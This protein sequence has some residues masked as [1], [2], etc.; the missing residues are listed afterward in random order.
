MTQSA[1]LLSAYRA[2]SHA[3]WADWLVGAC[4][5][6][7]WRRFELPG[8]H[9]AWRIRGNPLSWLDALADGP[10]PERFVATSMVD[11]ATVRGL[12]PRLASVPTLLYFHENQF[13]YPT[14]NRQTTSIEAQMV[15][16]YAALAAD[17]VAFNSAFNRDSFLAG[18]SAL[19]T[20]L[21]DRVPSGVVERIEGKSIVLPVPIEPIEPMPERDPALIVWNQRWEYDRQPERFAE[22]MRKL[23]ERGVEFRLALLGARPPHVPP[24][25]AQLRRMLP[26]RIV[27]DAHLPRAEY[28]TLLARAGL[29][30]STSAHEFQGLALLE[31]VSA[32]C[33]PLV[34]D[35]LVYPEIYPAEY[36][37]PVGDL[38]ALVGRLAGWLGG[39][40]PMPPDVGPWRTENL[41]PRWRAV[42]ESTSRYS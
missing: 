14:R 32:G 35:A 20:R 25:L 23:A 7:N 27:V 5:A 8:R 10:P 34:P 11:L 3:A 2:D 1:W 9:F 18:L 6:Y 31:A 30:V 19:L 12:H 26:D 36:R 22:A 42:L 16:V 17:V 28:R 13:A 15:Q 41:A 21:P 37:Y 40:R 39:G 33:L 24:A 38:D 29:V 4:D